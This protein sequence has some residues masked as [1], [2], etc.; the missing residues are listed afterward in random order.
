M[1]I[2]FDP[3]VGTSAP[4]TNS[5]YINFLRCVT[6]ACTAAAGTTTLTVNPYTAS[7]TI[8]T[9]KNCILSIDAN[10]EAGGWTTSSSH[11]VPSSGNN[12]AQ[13]FTAISSNGAYTTNYKADFHVASGKSTYPFLKLAFHIPVTNTR[14][15]N[16]YNGPTFP[17]QWDSFPAVCSTFGHS[18]TNNWSDTSFVPTN[19]TSS[20]NNAFSFTPFKDMGTQSVDPYYSMPYNPWFMNMSQNV[21][22]Y[23]IAVT[24][25]YCIIWEINNASNSYVTGYNT[26]SI[27]VGYTSYY[28]RY[29]SI[30]YHGLRETQGWENTYNDNPPWVSWGYLHSAVNRTSPQT[31]YYHFPSNSVGAWMRTQTN[32]SQVSAPSIKAVQS[33]GQTMATS[34][35]T[36][37]AWA[38]RQLQVPLFKT[39]NADGPYMGSTSATLN[40]PQADPATGLQVPGAYPIII[41]ST[42][43]DSY[44]AGG[45]CRGIYKSLSMPFAN[46]KNYWTAENQTF[47]INGETYIPFVIRE[48]MWLVRAA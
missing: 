10:T 41:R 28:Q 47:T 19:N 18:T 17:G 30:I 20:H 12:I 34:D 33:D 5:T 43:N 1:I 2:T 7:N 9:T 8:D 37:G 42:Q 13:S 26:G 15:N 24:A 11:N 14:D 48:D 16:G 6:A 36:M 32:T 40:P 38:S 4:D 25:N 27:G 31:Y 35:V 21:V 45:A 44:N 39:R 3:K 23:K 22:K 46:M 29:G